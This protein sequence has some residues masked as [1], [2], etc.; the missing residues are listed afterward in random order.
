MVSPGCWSRP[1]TGAVYRRICFVL[2]HD[3]HQQHQLG[4]RQGRTPPYTRRPGATP[5]PG[6]LRPL[7]FQHFASATPKTLSAALPAFLAHRKGIVQNRPMA[8]KAWRVEVGRGKIVLRIERNILIST[9]AIMVKYYFIK[10][11]NKAGLIKRFNFNLSKKLNDRKIIIPF[12]NGIGLTNFVIKMEW[13]DVLIQGFAN[14]VQAGFVD[15][16]VNIGQTILRVKTILPDA[17]YLGFEPNSTCT[18]YSQSLVKINNFENCIIQNCALSDKVQNLKLEKTLLDD[19]RAS[20]VSA[21]RPRYFVDFE[22]VIALNYDAFYLG[23][24][25]GFI[26]IDVEGAELEVLKGMQQS[27]AKYRPIIACEVLDSHSEE[28]FAFTQGR[29]T[30][31]SNL[32]KSLDYTIIQLETSKTSHN[33]VAYMEHETIRLQ[34]W[35]QRS[36]ELNDY[37]FIPIERSF[38][39]KEQLNKMVK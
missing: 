8:G 37:L 24:A 1:C 12:V 9:F 33:I 30:E 38:E 5:P 25:I 31:L 29:A 15:V 36:S 39:L 14:E 34:Q 13:L 22:H 19:S 23:R 10:A 11:L 4:I 20:V 3:R 17:P 27:I 21:L 18:S 7:C 6:R 26:K 2:R 16:G 32:L 35:T 28:A